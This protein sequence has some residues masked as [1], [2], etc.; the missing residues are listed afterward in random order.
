MRY[1]AFLLFFVGY[2]TIARFAIAGNPDAAREA[3]LVEMMEK[4]R[5]LHTA[6]GEPQPGDWLA[7]YDEPGQTFREYL[8]CDRAGPTEKRRVIYLQPLGP[9]TDPHREIIKATGDF[10]A[11]YFQLPVKLRP[12]WP[13]SR[14]PRSARRRHPTQGTEQM[15]TSYVLDELLLPALPA[16][17]AAMIALT[18]TDLWPGEGWNYVFGEAST[19]DRVGVWSLRRYGD[20]SKNKDAFLLCLRRAIA[21]ASHEVGH[22]FSMDHCTRYQCNMGG[23]N[24]LEESDRG[25]LAL[26]PECLAKLCWATGAAPARRFEQLATFCQRAGLTREK[27]FYERSWRALNGALMAP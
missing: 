26:C 20:P 9:F 5:S 10:L 18:V 19:E 16:D 11:R 21:T 13:A 17:A 25:P 1:M 24:S 2:S 6:P 23:S 4:L 22:M 8:D 14:V 27:A 3:Q 12:D 7:L 15:L